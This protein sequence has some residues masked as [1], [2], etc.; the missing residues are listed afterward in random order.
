MRQESHRSC[1]LPS[2]SRRGL[3]N[4]LLV[5]LGGALAGNRQQHLLLTRSGL[6]RLFAFRRALLSP[7][8]LRSSASMRFTTFSPRG[9]TLSR[10]GHSIVWEKEWYQVFRFAEEEHAETFM[11]EFGGERMHPSEKGKG[12]R[13]S[14]WK[15]GTYKPKPV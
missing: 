15:K 7:A 1:T 5:L 10:N 2:A 12:K 4:P 3:I 14:T 6:A 9:L 13:W 8:I 11:K